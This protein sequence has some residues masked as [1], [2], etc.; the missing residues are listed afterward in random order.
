M[1]ENPKK[2]PRD[3]S[4]LKARLGLKKGGTAAS[5]PAAVPSPLGTPRGDPAMPQ[6]PTP[7]SVP[8]AQP[9]GGVPAPVRRYLP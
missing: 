5:M 4:D 2:G 7:G 8:A 9:R 3:I 1:D 6:P